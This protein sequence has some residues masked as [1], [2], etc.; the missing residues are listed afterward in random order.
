MKSFI[1]NNIMKLENGTEIEF[2]KYGRLVDIKSLGKRW[3]ICGSAYGKSTHM[4]G[5]NYLRKILNTGLKCQ[6]K[7]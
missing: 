4:A 2:K 7:E 5:F 6:S 1:M 3:M